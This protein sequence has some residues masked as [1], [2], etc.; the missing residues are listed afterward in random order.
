MDSQGTHLILPLRLFFQKLLL[1]WLLVEWGITNIQLE[2]T[3]VYVWIF[4]LELNLM[5]SF[6]NENMH[7]WKQKI[8]AHK[9]RKLVSSSFSTLFV[10]LNRQIII[11]MQLVILWNAA[12]EGTFD[13]D[14]EMKKRSSLMTILDENS[15]TFYW[16]PPA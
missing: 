5:M 11:W 6:R 2:Y 15:Y 9:W 3:L 10:K 13:S 14:L 1:V 8:W 16:I 12:A 7:L 4:W